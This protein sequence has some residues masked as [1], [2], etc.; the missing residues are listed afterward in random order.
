M[1]VKA[2]ACGVGVCW[3]LVGVAEKKKEEG[4]EARRDGG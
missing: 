4:G 1:E 2:E 3:K